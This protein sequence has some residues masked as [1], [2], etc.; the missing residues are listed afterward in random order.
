MIA[1]KLTCILLAAGFASACTTVP[2]KS[3]ALEGSLTEGPKGD[4]MP[5]PSR[6]EVSRAEVMAALCP[7]DMLDGETCTGCPEDSEGE[8]PLT[9]TDIR[10]GSYTAPGADE[11][12]V[13]AIGCAPSYQGETE[14]V[15]MR[16]E[17]GSFTVLARSGVFFV[18]GC[19]FP[20]GED[21]VEAIVCMDE[22]G[23]QGY[24]YS[25]VRQFGLDEEMTS[26]EIFQLESNIAACPEAGETAKNSFGV[27]LRVE[28]VD[29]DGLDDVVLTYKSGDHPVPGNY[30]DYCEA[31][32]DGYAFPEPTDAEAVFLQRAGTF[33]KQ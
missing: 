15:V 4:I 32:G 21:G 20:M 3:D 18:S 26:T 16:R 30:S 31:E 17:G 25:T 2:K 12:A 13:T 23:N 10:P 19:V 1:R 28:D 27:A 29:G 8:G 6:A 14:G 24:M 22:D 7:A 11:V 33:V 9:V 5:K